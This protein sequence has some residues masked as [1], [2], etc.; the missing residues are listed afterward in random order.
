MKTIIVDNI[1]EINP[2]KEN[3]FINEFSGVVEYKKIQPFLR[4]TSRNYSSDTEEDSDSRSS[5]YQRL[6]NKSRV[7]EIERFLIDHYE[8]SELEKS[9]PFPTPVTLSV[10]SE[11]LD[12]DSNPED[13]FK[14]NVSLSSLIYENKLYLNP[15]TE[16][17]IFIVDGQHRLAGIDLFV[18][19]NPTYDVFVYFTLLINYDLSMQAKVF[20]NINFKVKPVNKSLYYDIFGSL[21]DEYNELTFAHMIVKRI[22]QDEDIGGLI[23]MLGTGSGTVSLAFMVET[24]IDELIKIKKGEDKPA[25]YDIYQLYAENQSLFKERYG[26]LGKLFV[27]YFEI[28]KD[29]LKETFPEKLDNGQYSSYHYDS[30]LTKTTG[31]YSLIKLLNLVDIKSILEQHSTDVEIKNDLD[32]KIKPIVGVLEK[33]QK[34]LFSKDGDF[35]TGGSKS[36]QRKLY[37][38][39][40]EL[41]P[42]RS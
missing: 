30:I 23:K 9:L 14:E 8:D 40:E 4:F 33:N 29:Q 3:S 36:L 11:Y 34:D 41:L 26:K 6:L 15:K 5:L 38:K 42:E 13:Y 22:N 7:K 28:L 25:L 27:W 35:A 39:I 21:P 10:E 19:N 37:S 18:K 12:S 24:I 20:A 31:M 2:S 17:S 32:E 16:K 1:I